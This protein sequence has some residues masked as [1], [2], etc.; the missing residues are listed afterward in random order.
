MYNL[1]NETWKNVRS[2]T[3]K[4][5]LDPVWDLCGNKIWNCAWHLTRNCI[6]DAINQVLKNE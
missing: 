5:T 2:V 1:Q 3:R 6:E 4:D